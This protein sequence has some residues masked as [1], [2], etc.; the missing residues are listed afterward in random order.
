MVKAMNDRIYYNPPRC[1]KYLMQQRRIA[2]LG[3][4]NKVAVITESNKK[5]LKGNPTVQLHYDGDKIPEDEFEELEKAM[6]NITGKDIA[7]VCARIVKEQ[8]KKPVFSDVLPQVTFKTPGNCDGLGDYHIRPI[9]EE[10]FRRMLDKDREKRKKECLEKAI[11]S[12]DKPK[13]R[14]VLYYD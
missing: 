7:K 2:E 5:D 11:E 1:G 12:L 14:G 6:K 4:N 9:A 8:K 13:K 3:K 10:E